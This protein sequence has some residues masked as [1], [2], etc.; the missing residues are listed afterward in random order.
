M[1]EQVLFVS[2]SP[3]D[4]NVSI[5]EP[6]GV[7]KIITVTSNPTTVSVPSGSKIV[8]PTNN[9]LVSN[10]TNSTVSTDGTYPLTSGLYTIQSVI[11]RL[12]GQHKIPMLNHIYDPLV[13][14][15]VPP[16]ITL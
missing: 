7:S 1:T 6:T 12:N 13:A 16:S 9:V 2:K 8:V 11:D 3:V 4:Y 15:P 14:E 10:A 5:L